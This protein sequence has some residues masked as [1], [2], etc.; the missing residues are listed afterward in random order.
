MNAPGSRA[1]A[2]T[3]VGASN[4]LFQPLELLIDKFFCGFLSKN[5]LLPNVIVALEPTLMPVPAV[6]LPA[7]VIA[8]PNPL[9]TFGS[10]V[11]KA[12]ATDLSV[13]RREQLVHNDE[14]RPRSPR[15]WPR[16]FGS[17]ISDWRRGGLKI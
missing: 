1:A 3:A 16:T 7:A 12:I 9:K 2:L 14:R 15:L 5:G 8:A 11:A 4:R 17:T 10:C 13:L 6:L